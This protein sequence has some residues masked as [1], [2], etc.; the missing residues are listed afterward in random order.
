MTDWITTANGLIA[1]ITAFVSLIGA[2]V[3]VFITIKTLIKSRKDKTAQD[4]WVF[5]MEVAKAAMS[6]AEESGKAGKTKKEMVIESV[7][8]SCKAAGIDINGFID[9]LMAFI[10]QS[11]AFANTIK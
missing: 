7:K 10:D 4:N 11:I 3:G 5:I 2:G 1:L 6:K 8:E 9:Q